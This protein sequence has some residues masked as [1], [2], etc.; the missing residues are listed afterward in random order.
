[1]VEQ[2]MLQLRSGVSGFGR[3]VDSFCDQ[4]RSIKMG[5]RS[6][7]DCIFSIDIGT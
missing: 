2:K 7:E 4:K 1:M 5:R 6:F 3:T